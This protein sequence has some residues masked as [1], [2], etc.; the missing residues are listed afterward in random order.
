M[1]ASCP[2]FPLSFKTIALAAAAIVIIHLAANVTITNAQQEQ[3]QQQL[4]TSQ[5]ATSSVTQN[6]TTDTAR[7]FEST[8]DNFRLQI[9]EGWVVREVLFW[10]Q[11]KRR[12]MEY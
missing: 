11:R 9:P 6:R 10:Q 2:F 1:R 5:P 3:E 4:L 7:L 8:S 12:G